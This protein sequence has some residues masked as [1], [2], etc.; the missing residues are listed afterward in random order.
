L[1]F[2]FLELL[3]VVGEGI[4]GTDLDIIPNTQVNGRFKNAITE[5]HIN[6]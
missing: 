5:F 2:T 3:T 6:I 1:L 4:S